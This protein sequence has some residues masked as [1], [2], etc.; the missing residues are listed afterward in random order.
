LYLEFD[1]VNKPVFGYIY[2]SLYKQFVKTS[3]LTLVSSSIPGKVQINLFYIIKTFNF[4]A[5][6]TLTVFICC[7]P[8]G[9]EAATTFNDI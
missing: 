3:K 2:N 9:L 8:E 6:I 1:L 4:E 5:A 7:S